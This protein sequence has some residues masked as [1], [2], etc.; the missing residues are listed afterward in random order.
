M[1]K[2]TSSRRAI[3]KA[4]LEGKRLTAYDANLIGQTT[5]GA[6]RIRQIRESY[7]V[8]KEPVPGEMYVR[9][10]M[11]P[12]WL[13]EWRKEHKKPIGQRIGEFFDNLLSGGMFEE[14]KA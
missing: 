7:P 3:L 1:D 5:A 2:I 11:D 4:L 10:Y 9:Y 12:E 13:A 8:L 14:A 6:R